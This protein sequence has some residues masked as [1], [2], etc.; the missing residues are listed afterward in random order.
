MPHSPK[1]PI[2]ID[3]PSGIRATAAAALGRILFTWWRLYRRPCRQRGSPPRGVGENLEQALARGQVAAQVLEH[4]DERI[5]R[6]AD[7]VGVGPDNVFPDRGGARGEPRGI[8]QPAAG[9]R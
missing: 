3:A 9:E 7:L 5:E 2:R 4:R 8:D 6:G 1:P